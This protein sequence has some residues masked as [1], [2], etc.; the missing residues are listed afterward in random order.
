M[1]PPTHMHP[2]I[3][4][5]VN[6]ALGSEGLS[7]REPDKAKEPA[8]SPGTLLGPAPFNIPSQCGLRRF[9]NKGNYNVS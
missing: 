9:V 5:R 1:P 2:V 8:C 7:N 4:K 6:L 3:L